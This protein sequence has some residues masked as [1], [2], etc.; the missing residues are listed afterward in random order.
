MEGWSDSP[1]SRALVKPWQFGKVKDEGAGALWGAW[2]SFSHFVS[3]KTRK[4][5]IKA[6]VW[7]WGDTQELLAWLQ[8]QTATES[9][10]SAKLHLWF[11]DIRRLYSLVTKQGTEPLTWR[12]LVQNAERFCERS[13]MGNARWL[14]ASSSE[15]WKRP[16]PAAHSPTAASQQSAARF[17]GLPRGLRRTNPT[18][19]TNPAAQGKALMGHQLNCSH[20]ILPPNQLNIYRQCY[21]PKWSKTQG[22]SPSR[23]GEETLGTWSQPWQLLS[24]HPSSSNWFLQQWNGKCKV[25][26]MSWEPGY[27][28]ITTNLELLAITI[29]I[30]SSLILNPKEERKTL[31]ALPPLLLQ[32]KARTIRSIC[33]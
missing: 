33:Q 29:K 30:Y 32:R 10:P 7:Q 19:R 14:L 8:K 21:N 1:P 28:F 17:P 16:A 12:S 4:S 11:A 31:A 13:E 5:S 26:A 22:K 18:G 2:L 25:L 6:N 23:Q 27:P 24:L 15:R 9:Q 20:K 3:F